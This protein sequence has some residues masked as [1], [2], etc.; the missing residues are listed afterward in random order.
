MPDVEHSTYITYTTALGHFKEVEVFSIG[1]VVTDGLISS[2]EFHISGLSCTEVVECVVVIPII[3][4]TIGAADLAGEQENQRILTWGA[5]AP[6]F[7]PTI[8]CIETPTL[9][10]LPGYK[11]D[12]GI[13]VGPMTCRT[14]YGGSRIMNTRVLAVV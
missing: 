11:L 6:S 13:G 10:D 7:L 3:A 8:L 9:V 14:L 12:I 2:E 1:Y 4:V 5:N